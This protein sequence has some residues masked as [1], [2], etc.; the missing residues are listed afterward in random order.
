MNLTNDIPE[1]C[2]YCPELVW[3]G[4]CCPDDIC[5]CTCKDCACARPQGS[6]VLDY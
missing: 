1:A 3:P 6:I 5:N 4:C 2:C